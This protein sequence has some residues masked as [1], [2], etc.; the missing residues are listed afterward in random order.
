MS[1][2]NVP[3]INVSLFGSHMCKGREGDFNG[4]MY[5]CYMICDVY[6]NIVVL[7]VHV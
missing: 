7:A 6:I 1:S 2:E 5:D 4:Y 3:H